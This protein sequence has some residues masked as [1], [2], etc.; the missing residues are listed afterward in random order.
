MKDADSI[1]ES[2]RES[3]ALEVMVRSRFPEHG[4]DCFHR[5][6]RDRGVEGLAGIRSPVD[7]ARRCDG[8][9]ALGEGVGCPSSCVA[10]TV[11]AIAMDGIGL[12]GLSF[13]HAVEIAN[14]AD[15][16]E[17]FMAVWSRYILTDAY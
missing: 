17:G 2:S 1:L 12:G 5:A 3:D 14:M 8:V 16:P 6:P 9:I 15:K 11:D 4:L 10:G 13:A 7:V